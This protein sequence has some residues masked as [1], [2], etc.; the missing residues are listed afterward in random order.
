MLL[1]VLSMLITTPLL[2]LWSTTLLSPG[3]DPNQGVSLLGGLAAGPLLQTSV[4]VSAALLLIFACNTALIG[5]YHVLIALGR[6]R[7]LPRALLAT[8]RLRGTP[9]WSIIL[10][11]VIPAAVIIA[12]GASTGLLGDLYAF[13]LLGA[14]SITCLSLDIVRWH[15]RKHRHPNKTI[16]RT[17][18]PIFLIGVA[19]TVLVVIPWLTNLVAKPLATAFGGTLVLIGLAVAIVTNRLEMR[20]GRY[21]IVPYLHR[22]EHPI[23]MLGRGRSLA[24]AAVLAFLPNDAKRLPGVIAEAISAARARPLVFAYQGQTPRRGNPRL[25]EILDPYAD[26]E[27]AHDAFQQA[28]AAARKGRTQARYVYAPAGGEPDFEDRLREQLNPEQV[29][30]SA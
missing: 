4:A 19:T 28:E 5:C 7:F 17:S 18:M 12:S 8:N 30:G 29:I 1:V 23:L 6:M 13:G 21:R 16:G 27:Q 15:E 2:T 24:P 14:F 25:L 10:A 22:P 20:R 26:D 3:F 9:H 11:T